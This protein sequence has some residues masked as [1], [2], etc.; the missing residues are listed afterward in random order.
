MKKKI[1]IIGICGRT[2]A[3]L[4]KMFKDLGWEVSGADQGAYPPIT[5]YLDD[6]HIPYFDSYQA[7]HITP[8]LDLVV[9]GG[10]TF[11]ITKQNPEVDQAKKLGLTVK[12]YPE[13]FHEYLE[14]PESILVIGTY[15][16]TTTC[17]LLAWVLETAGRNPSFDIGEIPE[18]FPDG[19]RNT[20]SRYSIIHGDEH[21]T[22]GYSELPKFAYFTPK[23][24]LLTAALWDHFNIYPTESEYLNVFKKR[25][26]QMP[27]DGFLL[28]K[29][30]GEHN[31]P[32]AKHAPCPVYTYSLV[33]P[34]ADFY[35][36]LSS[37]KGEGRGDYKFEFINNKGGQRFPVEFSMLGKHNVENAVGAIAMALLLG[38]KPEAI[39]KAMQTFKGLKRHLELIFANQQVTIYKDQGQHPKKFQAAVEALKDQYPDRRLIAIIDPHASVLHDIHSLRFYAHTLDKADQVIIA[40]MKIRQL[41][42]GE[43]K[44][45]RVTGKKI[46]NAI[47]K[48]QPHVEYLPVD[49]QILKWLTA[50]HHSGDVLL[51]LT[52]GGFRNLISDA[53]NLFDHKQ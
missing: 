13:V 38:V 45:H 48:T 51:F 1:Y 11:H 25:I 21:P 53:V 16:K 49:K 18:N 35:A 28:M 46:R 19:T 30:E 2:M 14:K 12:S 31:Q 7:E 33:D 15:G 10:N 47:Q 22:L 17:T 24:L 8:D 40:M 39:Q 9:V 32:L 42:K 23:Y 43:P 4:A 37:Q 41:K 3:P 44:Q 20:D 36:S 52:T 27:K 29:L 5:D 6:N 50:N 34:Q 26:Q